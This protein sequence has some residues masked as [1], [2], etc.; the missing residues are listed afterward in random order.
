MYS[1]AHAPYRA[2]PGKPESYQ[3]VALRPVA[4]R[5]KA[6]V[7]LP[8]SALLSSFICV[9]IATA[10]AMSSQRFQHWFVIPITLCGVLAGIDA[11]DWIRGKL[12]IYDP[13]GLVGAL[14]VHFFFLAPLLH[15]YWQEF[16][17]V[18]PPADWRDWLGGMGLLNLLG[19]TAYRISRN[20]FNGRRNQLTRSYWA[21]NP[22]TLTLLGPAM[23]VV[24]AVAQAAVYAKFGGIS[25]YM[26]TRLSNSTA[27]TG[28]GWM[29]MVSESFPIVAAVLG[30]AYARQRN[31]SWTKLVTALA[32]LFVLLM[33]FGGL[34]GSRSNTVEQLFWIVGCIHFLIRPVPRKLI[35][36]GI[37]FM[38]AFMYLY[39]F[40]KEGNTRGLVDAGTR[41]GIAQKH[42][43]TFD[44]MLLGDLG[45][46]DVQAYI[47]YKVS[48]HMSDY[49]YA[50]GRTYAGALSLLIP[51]AILPERPE[52]TL[53]EGTEIQGGSGSYVPNL[54]TSSKVYGLG[55]EAM[56]NFGPVAVPVVYAL[57][58]LLVGWL[59][60]ALQRLSPGDIRLFFVPFGI[61]VCLVMIGADSD[62]LIFGIFKFGLV[63]ALLIY[64]CSTKRRQYS[65]SHRGLAV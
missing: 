42:G 6:G 21:L 50:W 16:F 4:L 32:I 56:L 64:V 33:L 48:T 55:G 14:S 22:A 27:F 62:N 19:L 60:T 53:K 51:H 41:S 9:L 36:L 11:I 58:G 54:V 7:V 61:Y 23:L 57:F 12:D 29:F 2:H 20:A 35:C 44:A 34:R 5:S 65:S 13:V 45:R 40:F 47:L 25:G 28:M 43:R 52:T 24:T 15:I 30:V 37:I 10:F 63:P 3:G 18:T 26:D 31:V 8:S 59:R 39:G 17:N 38:L 49:T 1:Q 46:A